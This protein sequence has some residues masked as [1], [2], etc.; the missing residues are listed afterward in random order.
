MEMLARLGAAAVLGAALGLERE[1][2]HRNAGLRTHL[3]VSLAASTLMLVST[4]FIY[5]Q[6][7]GPNDLVR[8]DPSRIAASVATGIGFLGAGATFKTGFGIQGLTTAASLWMAAALGLAAGGG[9][10]VMA[11]VSAVVA[12]FALFVLRRAEHKHLKVI[13]RKITVEVD[14]GSLTHDALVRRLKEKSV[15]VNGFEIDRAARDQR[16]QI[17]VDVHFPDDDVQE[18]V[19][20]ELESLPGLRRFRIAEPTE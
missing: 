13:H 6:S 16:K 19:I 9:M 5:F 3:L 11:A 7:Y 10:Y 17:V 12:L 4:Q 2:A 18:D 15:V 20:R 1:H 14:E 8:T